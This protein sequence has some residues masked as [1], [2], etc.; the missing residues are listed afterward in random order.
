MAKKKKSL[1]SESTR[2]LNKLDIFG[3]SIRLNYDGIHETVTTSF[4][5][6]LT[7]LFF[8]SAIAYITLETFIMVTYG[9]TYYTVSDSETDIQNFKY[10]SLEKFGHSFNMIIGSSNTTLDM[11]NN[12]YVEFKVMEV[13]Q[14]WK[15]H[16]SKTIQLKTCT[17]ADKRKFITDYA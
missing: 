12:P 13:K 8:G 15:P 5:G 7:I 1:I 17:P 16:E 6:I 9:D 4:G 2:V 14:D 3:R 10:D 11:L